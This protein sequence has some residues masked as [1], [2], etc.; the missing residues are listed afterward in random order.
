MLVPGLGWPG[1]GL[2]GWI[3]ELKMLR[4]GLIPLRA[5]FDV[6]GFFPTQNIL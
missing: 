1:M 6:G 2:V 4:L 5:G 3:M